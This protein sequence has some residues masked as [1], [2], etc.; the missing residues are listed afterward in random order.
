MAEDP[1]KGVFNNQLNSIWVLA[2][3]I[4]EPSLRG[5]FRVE[6]LLVLGK[7]PKQ[8]SGGQSCGVSSAASSY[9]INMKLV[10]V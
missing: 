2:Q 5:L 8:P 3:L 9:H 6:R 1:A 7:E 10:P 4:S